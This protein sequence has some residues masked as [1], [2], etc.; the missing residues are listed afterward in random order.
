MIMLRMEM[1]LKRKRRNI[2]KGLVNAWTHFEFN[3]VSHFAGKESAPGH[4]LDF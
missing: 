2:K 1:R 3:K 4:V